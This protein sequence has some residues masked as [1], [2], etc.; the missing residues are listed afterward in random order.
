MTEIAYHLRCD[1]KKSVNSFYCPVGI[2]KPTVKN[3][4]DYYRCDHCGYDYICD[5]SI[6]IE[7]DYSDKGLPL[8]NTIICSKCGSQL[9][10]YN[11]PKEADRIGEGAYGT[12]YTSIYKR[13]Y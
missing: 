9:E 13:N 6:K 11:W 2:L 12:K 7:F 5:H 8:Q 1:C 3:N 4:Y 10:V